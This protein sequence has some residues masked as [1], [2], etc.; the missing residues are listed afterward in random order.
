L[1]VAAVMGDQ[2]YPGEAGAVFIPVRSGANRNLI[3]EQGAGLG[4]AAGVASDWM[5]TIRT[6]MACLRGCLPDSM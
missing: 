2:V 6:P 5:T 4:A 1:R 3:L